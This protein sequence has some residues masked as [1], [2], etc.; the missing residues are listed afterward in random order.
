[1]LVDEDGQEL[2][3]MAE[4]LASDGLSARAV[5]RALARSIEQNWPADDQDAWAAVLLAQE[6]AATVRPDAIPENA[7]QSDALEL[8]RY[9]DAM[10][11]MIASRQQKPPISIVVFGPWGSG[12]SFFMEMI[13]EAITIFAGPN[14]PVG[15]FIERVV[16]I[17]FNAWHY[18]EGNLWASLVHAILEGLEGELNPAENESVF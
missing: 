2:R 4:R 11:A 6:D 3:P 5:C 1:M 16:Q 18:V 15:D 8:R 10:G 9:A 12:K 14:R 13:R 17:P 7:R